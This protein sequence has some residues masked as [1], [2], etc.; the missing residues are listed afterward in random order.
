MGGTYKQKHTPGKG[1]VLFK[2][3]E[4]RPHP[5]DNTFQR[6]IKKIKMEVY[7]NYFDLKKLSTT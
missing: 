3:F 7:K 4:Y 2:Y 6:S 5:V 1:G